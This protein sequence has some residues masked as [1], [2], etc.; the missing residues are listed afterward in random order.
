MRCGLVAGKLTV[1]SVASTQRP[2]KLDHHF[3]LGGEMRRNRGLGQRQLR[4]Q[5]QPGHGGFQL[6]LDDRG[7]GPHGQRLLLLAAGEGGLHLAAQPR[8]AEEGEVD[9]Q[10]HGEAGVFP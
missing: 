8:A 2:R 3:E 10:G 7:R 1:G 5:Q 9:L 6:V 4:L